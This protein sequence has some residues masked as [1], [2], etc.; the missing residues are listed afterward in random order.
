VKDG[1]NDAVVDGAQGTVNPQSLGTKV[2]AHYTLV[3]APGSTETVILRLSA[4]QHDNP[5]VDA[6][7]VFK[8]RQEEAD[9]FYL[10][11]GAKNLSAD[12]RSVQRQAFAGLLWSKQFYYYDVDMWLHGDPAGPTP[13]DSRKFGRNSEWQHLNTYD[14]L[15]MPDTWE[16]PWYAAW[17]LAFHCIP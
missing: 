13:P 11:C 8:A 2:A 12:A 15:S 16:Y 17:D 6:E 5:F 3:V 7:K 4:T 9:S 14:I 10:T 1:I